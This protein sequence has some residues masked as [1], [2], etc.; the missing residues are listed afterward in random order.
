MRASKPALFISVLIILFGTFW[1]LSELN[2]LPPL[3]WLWTLGLATTGVLTLLLGGINKQ[4]L[5]VGPYLVI[6]AGFSVLRQ[7]SSITLKME[8]PCL[9]IGFGVW[10]FIVIM[11]GYSLP[12]LLADD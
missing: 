10:L 8:I 6:C 4:T 11:C 7:T 12:D 9:V 3:H 1:L 5:V 2:L